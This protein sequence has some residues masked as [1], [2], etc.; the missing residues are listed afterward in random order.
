MDQG[1]PPSRRFGVSHEVADRRADAAQWAAT[2]AP[3][4]DPTMTSMGMWWSISCCT[5]PTAGVRRLTNLN[6]GNAVAEP[7]S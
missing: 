7:V 3:A 2:I 1:M 4:F 5:A 6:C